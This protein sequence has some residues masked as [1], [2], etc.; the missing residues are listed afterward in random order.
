MG[1]RKNES[2][3]FVDAVMVELGGDAG[4]T[5]CGDAVIVTVVPASCIRPM[6]IAATV[7]DAFVLTNGC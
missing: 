3:G 5:R 7:S 4:E 6:D 1:V 2:M